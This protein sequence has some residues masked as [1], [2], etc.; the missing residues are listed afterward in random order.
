MKQIAIAYFT[1][2]IIAHFI[3]NAYL[4]HLAAKRNN[5]KILYDTCIASLAFYMLMLWAR[6]Y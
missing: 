3:I 2:G 5:I 1:C 6:N 4:G